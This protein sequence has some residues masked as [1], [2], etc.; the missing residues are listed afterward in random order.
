MNLKGTGN[1]R[2]QSDKNH[3]LYGSMCQKCPERE[4]HGNR[5]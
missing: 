1:E 2:S 3:V 4:I 5:K